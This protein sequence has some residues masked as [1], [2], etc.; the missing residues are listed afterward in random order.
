MFRKN[1]VCSIFLVFFSLS[2]YSQKQEIN[3][4]GYNIFYHENGKIASEG[5]ME[6]N[7]P[8]GLW[9][10][11]SVNGNIKTIG[12]RK[13]GELDSIW[14]FYTEAGKKDKEINYRK[15][16]RNG[17][18]LTYYNS[19]DSSYILSKELYFEDKLNGTSEFYNPNGSLKNKSEYIDGK[20]HGF[21]KSYNQTGQIYLIIK[22]IKG[23]VVDSEYLNRFDN[24]GR[25]YGIWKEFYPNERIKYQASYID[26]KLNGYYREYDEYGKLIKSVLYSQGRQV[27]DSPSEIELDDTT[28]VVSQN[29]KEKIEYFENGKIKSKKQTVSD[30][31]HGTQDYFDENGNR[32][33]SEIYRYGKIYAQG[34]IDENG[35]YQGEW[36]LYYDSGK[37]KAKGNYISSVREGQWIFYFENGETEQTGFFEKGKASGDWIWF[38][39]SKKI[40]R[41]GKFNNNSEE[42]LFVE[43]SETGDTISQ[44]NYENGFKEGKWQYNINDLKESGVYE[45]GLKT[46]VWKEYFTEGNIKFEGEFKRD[47][48]NGKH[49]FYYNDKKI[50][51]IRYYQ[52][53]VPTDTWF[54][55]DEV[56][57]QY[58][59]QEYKYGEIFRINGKKVNKNIQ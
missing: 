56:G 45:K 47:L 41:T 15:G 35:K 25:K 58:L 36:K 4:N 38:Y 53:G 13:S 16:K 1:L 2:I 5:H 42:G 40:R 28:K 52:N 26:G 30:K 10:S 6:N 9:K 19:N 59:I 31:Q 18:L 3:P 7:V 50:K 23:N 22:Y 55:Y 43:F 33:L 27:V 12:Y 11:Y 8:T 54:Y 32:I 46:G 44:G 34:L 14:L 24:Q 57:Y 20:K 51:E 21:E 17:Y 39:E 48:A 37:I 29:P 49:I